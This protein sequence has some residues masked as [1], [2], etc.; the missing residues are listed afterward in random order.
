MRLDVKPEQIAKRASVEPPVREK[1]EPRERTRDEVVADELRKIEA[2]AAIAELE[3]RR[4]QETADR[5]EQSLA[6]IAKVLPIFKAAQDEFNGLKPP[7][8]EDGKV[9]IAQVEIKSMKDQLERLAL[10]AKV[11]PDRERREDAIRQHDS[12]VGL[13]NGL[14]AFVKSNREARETFLNKSANCSVRIEESSR[15]ILSAVYEYISN[16]GRRS[17]IPD[18]E[19]LAKHNMK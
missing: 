8:N 19:Y 1:G 4:K 6:I 5:R 7:E 14:V 2:N 18:W 3:R 9:E 10:L 15:I 13:F 12:K 11:D 17:E 16:D